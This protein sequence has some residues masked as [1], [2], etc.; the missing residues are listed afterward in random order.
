MPGGKGQNADFDG[1]SRRKTRRNWGICFR[2]SETAQAWHFQEVES[3]QVHHR[4]L[5]DRKVRRTIKTESWML[6]VLLLL[7][8]K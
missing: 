4:W 5:M 1:C 8:N 6:A 7:N 2:K 3:N